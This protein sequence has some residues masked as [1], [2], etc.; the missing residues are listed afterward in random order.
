MRSC[1][2]CLLLTLCSF[3][4]FAQSDNSGATR[5]EGPID[6]TPPQGVTVDQ[7]IQKFAAKETEFRQ[8]WDQYA[9][10]QDVKVQ[11]LDGDTVD[12]EFREVSDITFTDA[13]KRI[14]NVQFAPQ[15]T[16]QKLQMTK[17]DFDDIRHQYPFVLSTD[18]LPSYQIL[19][20]GRQRVDELDTYIFD[21]APKQ[22]EKNKRYVQ[23]RVWIDQQDLQIVKTHLKPAFQKSKATENQLFPA[24]TTYRE[25]IDGTYWF[26]TYVKADE[27]LHFPGG[28]GYPPNDVHIRIIVKYTDYKR[29]GAKSRIIFNGEELPEQQNPQQQKPQ[30]QPPAQQPPQQQTPPTKPK[31]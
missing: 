24:F 30:Q 27:V 28:R 5:G 16:L 2:A 26:P 17:E 19:Y 1:F 11:T 18:E 20:V 14:E 9:F 10:R 7:I 29:F 23:G 6:P 12:G 31:N 13:G 21:I 8:A 15:S 25:Q 3:A 22:L 4:A